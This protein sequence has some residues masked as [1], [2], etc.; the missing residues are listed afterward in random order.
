MAINAKKLGLHVLCWTIISG[1]ATWLLWPKLAV[2]TAPKPVASSVT[3]PLSIAA[4]QQFWDVLHRGDYTRIEEAMQP[5]Q[6][7]LLKNPDDAVTASH[8]GWLHIWKL[9]EASRLP[10]LT[11]DIPNHA[12]L[13]HHYFAEAA[14][15][16]PDDARI[17]GF[18]AD[19]EMTVASITKNEALRRQGYFRGKQAIKNWP[20]FNGFTVG[21][22]LTGALAH[23]D[24]QFTTGVDMMW[25]N[26]YACMLNDAFAKQDIDLRTFFNIDVAKQP[27]TWRRACLNS[28][29]APYNVE[30]FMLVLGDAVIKS[31][32]VALGKKI[33]AQIPTIPTF[34]SWPYKHVVAERIQ[35]AESNVQAFRQPTRKPVADQPDRQMVNRENTMM[36]N[37]EYACMG[38]H[39]HSAV[40]RKQYKMP[41]F[42]A[43]TL[44]LSKPLLKP[45]LK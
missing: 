22:V 44:R 10:E 28:W 29:I 18:L 21:Y 17:Q 35:R 1:I 40:S 11:P 42:V 43:N 27:E 4:N 19:L 30:G 6:A 16:M 2:W 37:T 26:T 14:A 45:S 33:Y 8:L 13:S 12:F 32:D 24:K 34:N 25:N 15:R 39:Q 23:D 38:C 9:S 20:E 7:A 5:L 41:A 36:F 3:T 31:G